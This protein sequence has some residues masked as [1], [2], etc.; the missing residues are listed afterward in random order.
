MNNMNLSAYDI[1]EEIL[2]KQKTWVCPK[3]KILYSRE[4]SKRRY[5]LLSKRFNPANNDT[6]FYIIMLDDKPLDRKVT[7][8]FVDNFGRLKIYIN[9]IWNETS[10][11]NIKTKSNITVEH[12]EHADDGDIYYLDI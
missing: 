6:S 7:R 10:L 1:V 5:A 12:V 11:R 9:S 8:S 4:I 2:D 3:T